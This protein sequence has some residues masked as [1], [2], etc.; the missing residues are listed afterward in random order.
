MK[1]MI[2]YFISALILF[3]LISCKKK[4]CHGLVHKNPPA[5]SDTG[6]N[7]CESIYYNFYTYAGDGEGHDLVCQMAYSPIKAYGYIHVYRRP[8]RNYYSLCDEPMLSNYEYPEIELMIDDTR[9]LDSVE[10]DCTKKYYVIGYLGFD[11][12]PYHG[13]NFGACLKYSPKF[14]SIRDYHLENGKGGVK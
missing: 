8:D 13:N 11:D 7:T 14:M 6:Y 10:I 5:L 2:I 12:H 9:E 4:E 3:S 1:R